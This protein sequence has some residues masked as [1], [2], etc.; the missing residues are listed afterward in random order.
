MPARRYTLF[1]ISVFLVTATV[2]VAI[3]SQNTATQPSTQH[4]IDTE[5]DVP[6]ADFTAP[7]PSDPDKRAERQARG[8]RHNLRDK[9]LSPEDVARFVLVLL[10]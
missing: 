8:K 10:R 3:H 5:F 1:L 4:V 6:I 7:E 2:A 9:N